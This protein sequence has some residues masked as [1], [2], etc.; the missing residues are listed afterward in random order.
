MEHV[1]DYGDSGFRAGRGRSNAGLCHCNLHNDS[2]SL[3]LIAQA[4]RFR[5]IIHTGSSGKREQGNIM[6]A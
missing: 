5:E 2:C 6:N 4:F 1:D 3:Q